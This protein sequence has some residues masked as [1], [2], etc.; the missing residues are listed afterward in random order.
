VVCL[1]KENHEI[2]TIA[3]LVKIS[4]RLAQEYYD[5]FQTLDITPNRSK[6][7]DEPVKKTIHQT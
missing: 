7:L 2:T 6:E 5:L 4:V 1:A 3:F